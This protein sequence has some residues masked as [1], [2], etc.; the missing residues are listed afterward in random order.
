MYVMQCLEAG[1]TRKQIVRALN[2]DEDLLDVW[3]S[4]LLQYDWIE[5]QNESG[6]WSVTAKG[7]SWYEKISRMS[8]G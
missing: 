6:E 8:I 4:F 7:K 1:Q 2:G 3:T 5:Q